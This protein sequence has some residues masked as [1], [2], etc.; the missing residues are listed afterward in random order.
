M[1]KRKVTVKSERREIFNLEVVIILLV[2]TLVILG[3][4]F[5]GVLLERDTLL[6]EAYQTKM[7]SMQQNEALSQLEMKLKD[8]Q[9]SQSATGGMMSK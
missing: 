1:A 6:N 2:G 7:Q 5:A 9:S 3:T 4:A 8:F